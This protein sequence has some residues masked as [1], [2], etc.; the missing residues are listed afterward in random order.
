MYKIYKII[1]NTNNNIYYGS[2]KTT[3]EKRLKQHINAYN[4]YLNHN[5]RKCCVVDILRNNNYNIELVENVDENV[6]HKDRE[7]YYIENNICININIPNRTV[8]EYQKKHY[9]NNKNVYIEQSKK[10]RENNKEQNYLLKKQWAE[11]NKE[12]LKAYYNEY[13]DKNRDIINARRRELRK[14]N[15]EKNIITN[16]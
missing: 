1:D 11:K 5:I 12:K 16:I 13:L 9:E 8:K 3:L 10:W 4:S 15:K 6:N 7:R 14:L 2:T